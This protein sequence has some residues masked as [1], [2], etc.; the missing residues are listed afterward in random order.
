MSM[1]RFRPRDR[2]ARFGLKRGSELAEMVLREPPETAD[3]EAQTT[4]V[5]D[6]AK[7]PDRDTEPLGGLVIADRLNLKCVGLH[8]ASFERLDAGQSAPKFG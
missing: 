4:F 3:P 7:D 2:C 8:L 1:A 5:D 6:F